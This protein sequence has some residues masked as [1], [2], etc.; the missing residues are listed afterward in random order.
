MQLFRIVPLVEALE[1]GVCPV[2]AKRTALAVVLEIGLL[3]TF[4]AYPKAAI[5]GSESP[6]SMNAAPS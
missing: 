1:T 5:R 3:A 4:L 2:E 6:Q